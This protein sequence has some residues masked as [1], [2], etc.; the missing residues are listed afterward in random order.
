[1]KLV[2]EINLDNPKHGTAAGALTCGINALTDLRN[3]VDGRADLRRVI[4]ISE[5]VLGH[6]NGVLLEAKVPG[7]STVSLRAEVVDEPM[8]TQSRHTGPVIVTERE[9]VIKIDKD[10]K[11]THETHRVG[12][13]NPDEAPIPTTAKKYGEI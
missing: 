8:N 6:V 1:M 7:E 2:I 11:T 12:F 9:G 3:T 13:A 5:R 10:G 4:K